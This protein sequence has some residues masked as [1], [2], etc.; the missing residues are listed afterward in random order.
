MN[1]RYEFDTTSTGDLRLSRTRFDT[2]QEAYRGLRDALEEWNQKTLLHGGA[3]KP[4][5]QEVDV[6]NSTIEWGN[7]KIAHSNPP[8]I[9]VI[10][11]SVGSC[12]YAVAALMLMIHR[13]IKERADKSKQGWPS[14]GL[15]SLD[16]A[17][18]GIRDFADS[19]DQE[20]SDVLWELIPK[21]E[22]LP[23]LIDAPG[24]IEWDVFISHANE[25]KE[26]FVR[27]LAKAL[28]AR[29]IS[30]WFDEFTLAVGDGLRR[31]IDN[32][33]AR[34]RFGVVVI[35]PHFLRKEWPQKE[36]DG[37]TAREVD[38]AKVILP[39]WHN[40]S[41]SEV[42]AYSPMLADRLATSSS[43]DLAQIVDELARV[44]TGG[45]ADRVA[46][47]NAGE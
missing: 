42:R 29:G 43:K 34:S 11:I 2:L 3:H 35:S 18:D 12:R 46:T 28:Q 24:G 33:L 19:F 5:E 20:P 13:R 45:A 32:G 6:L 15:R 7:E 9:T 1:Y 36:L 25:D 30:V 10:G 26:E 22:L 31:S 40:L 8:E 38:G 41:A 23:Q 16:E 14:S 27:P 4:Y 37:L 21:N 39:V 44:I 17:I 47:P